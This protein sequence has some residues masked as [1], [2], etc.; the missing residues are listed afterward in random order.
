MDG[1]NDG[2]CDDDGNCTCKDN[3]H[4]K[5]CGQCKQ[6]FTGFPNCL[7][8]IFLHF[9]SVCSWLPYAREKTTLLN[10]SPILNKL[11]SKY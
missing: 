4:G 1:S 5:K 7:I 8:G 3:F 2:F 10:M 11:P 6:G 9:Q